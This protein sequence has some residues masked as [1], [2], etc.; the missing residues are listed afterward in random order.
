MGLVHAVLE[1][2][3]AALQQLQELSRTQ[4]PIILCRLCCGLCC[5][6]V[7]VQDV[8]DLLHECGEGLLCFRLT[9]NH[10]DSEGE[11]QEEKF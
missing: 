7:L 11:L 4:F 6:P 10:L 8:C 1:A 5:A 3:E 2:A 9:T